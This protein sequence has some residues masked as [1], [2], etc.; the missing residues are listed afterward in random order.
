M[1]IDRISGKHRNPSDIKSVIRKLQD[2]SRESLNKVQKYLNKRRRFVSWL[3]NESF[4]T[5]WLK[6]LALSAFQNI[7]I[8]KYAH[9]K[10]ASTSKEDEKS[11][12]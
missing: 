6:P 7:E 5:Y 3:T 2:N 1:E 11:L 9:R 12:I 10:L 4:F 8:W